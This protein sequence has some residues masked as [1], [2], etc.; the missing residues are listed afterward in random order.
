MQT[1]KDYLTYY[2][3]LDVE[4]FIEALE[5]Q[6]QIYAQKN[7]DMLKSAISLPG[8]A[9][10]WMF[11]EVDRSAFDISL[12]DERNKDVY[13]LVKHNIV[14]GPSIVFHRYHEKDVTKLRFSEYGSEAKLCKQVLG[15]DANALYLWSMMQEMPTGYMIRRYE[16]N[17]FKPQ[18]SQKYGRQAWTWLEYLSHTLDIYIEHMFN[19]GE[20]RIGQHAIPVDGFCRESNTV[21]QFHG[22]LFHGHSNC[23]ITQ[24]KQ[25]NP[26]NNRSMEDLFHSTMH[27][28]EYIRAHGYNLITIFECHWQQQ[29]ELDVETKQFVCEFERNELKDC[30][31]KTLDQMLTMIKNEEYFGLV[32]CTV[33]VPD[34]LKHKFSE[35]CPIFKNIP[36]SRKDLSDHM[37]SF[38]SNTNHLMVP[39]RMLVGSLY[40]EKILILSKLA[41]W[42]LDHGLEITRIYQFIQFKPVACFRTFGESVSNS[43]REGDIDEHKTLLAETSKLVGNSVYG[44]T[45]TNQEKHRD[46]KYVNDS[47]KAS[48]YIKSDRYIHME[49]IEESFY[50]MTLQKCKVCH[51]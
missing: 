48:N 25:F 11:T 5:K 51:M 41:K 34:H 27:K 23:P 14:G 30:G 43:R 16:H 8:L 45:I 19:K 6:T 12:I 10:C 1:M 18:L 26:V 22:C 49:E 28:E 32:E 20:V 17:G 3:E 15:V 33:R 9:V 7:I 42:Y 46:I 13:T 4:P 29:V 24:D 40:G 31:S 36:V 2:A 47:R 37:Q 21:Y 38:A 39:Q 44:K 35:M 50:E